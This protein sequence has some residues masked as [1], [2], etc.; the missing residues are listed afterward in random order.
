M[1]F[2]SF[3]RTELVFL[4]KASKPTAAS[5]LA[6]LVVFALAFQDDVF[7]HGHRFDRYE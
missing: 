6:C 4:N 3:L 7:G 2:V 5:K 1:S